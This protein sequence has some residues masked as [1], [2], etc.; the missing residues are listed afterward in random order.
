LANEIEKE[1]PDTAVLNQ[2]SAKTGQLYS[3]LTLE[4]ALHFYE[5]GKLCTTEQKTKLF[6][7]YRTTG[8]KD[9]ESKG[10]GKQWRHRHGQGKNR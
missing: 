7:T 8:I 3:Q 1:T 5:M 9:Q 6:E 2:L 4:T 10:G